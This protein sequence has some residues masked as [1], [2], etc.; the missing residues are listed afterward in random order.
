MHLLAFSPFNMGKFVQLTDAKT[1]EPIYPITGSY[2]ELSEED[3]ET[4][5]DFEEGMSEEDVIPKATK[6]SLG[7]VVVGDG[8]EVDNGVLSNGWK[9]ELLWQNASPTSTMVNGTKIPL[10]SN[11][12][13]VLIWLFHGQ[14]DVSIESVS[15]CRKGKS[16]VGLTAAYTDTY[17]INNRWIDYVNDNEYVCGN[18][19]TFAV[20]I[21]HAVNNVV[22]IPVACYGIKGVS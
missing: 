11:D 12:Y 19:M 16:V 21:S 14:I 3:I 4:I 1:G 2:S 18:A 7:C 15:M 10:S 17:R 22:C 20:G 5:C 13:D 8:L 6:N 9:M